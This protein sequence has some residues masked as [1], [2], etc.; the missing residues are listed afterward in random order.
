ML[1]CFIVVA[2][3]F[4]DAITFSNFNS[5][6]IKGNDYILNTW[7]S[8]VKD[9]ILRMFANVLTVPDFKQIIV[10]SLATMNKFDDWSRDLRAKILR[11]QTGLNRS[12][13]IY[14]A[15]RFIRSETVKIKAAIRKNSN[16]YSD[17]KLQAQE[18]FLEMRV[19]RLTDFEQYICNHLEKNFTVLSIINFIQQVFDFG[20][21]SNTFVGEHIA[22]LQICLERKELAKKNYNNNNNNNNNNTSN[23]TYKNKF[24]KSKERKR[25]TA[26]PGEV[27]KSKVNDKKEG[28]TEKKKLYTLEK[29]SGRQCV[30]FEGTDSKSHFTPY[31]EDYCIFHNVTGDCDSRC[32]SR[33]LKHLCLVCDSTGHGAVHCPDLV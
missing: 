5:G 8:K 27:A 9:N 6:A 23:K 12:E 14:H 17:K 11:D 15:L 25:S 13:N 7:K 18:T 32:A 31:K 26:T 3:A 10:H 20:W 30:V 28:E 21:K 16:F 4:G 2:V 33:G 24:N 1:F 19:I 22:H 29:R